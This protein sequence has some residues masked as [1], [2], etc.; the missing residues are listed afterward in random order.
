MPKFKIIA[1]SWRNTD[2]PV[3][4]KYV[5]GDVVKT[6]IELDKKFTNAFIRVPDDTPVDEPTKYPES[7]A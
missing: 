5:R 1:R 6:D 2:T 7:C 4:H 3:R